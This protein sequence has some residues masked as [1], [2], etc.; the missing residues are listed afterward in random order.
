MQT[1]T[2]CTRGTDCTPGRARGSGMT[3]G[4]LGAQRRRGRRVAAWV[5]VALVCIVTVALLGAYWKFRS[6]WSSINRVPVTDLGKRPPKYNDALNLLVFASG[7][8]A[9]LTRR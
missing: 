1:R 3:F 9:G 7:S 6:V 4:E 8:T 5:S 2:G